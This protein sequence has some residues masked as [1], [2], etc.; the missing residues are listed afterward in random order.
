MRPHNSVS[1]NTWPSLRLS[2]VES[3]SMWPLGSEQ[4]RSLNQRLGFPGLPTLAQGGLQYRVPCAWPVCPSPIRRPP[5][6]LPVQT[7]LK[8]KV[9]LGCGSA[10]SL[11]EAEAVLPMLL[12][13]RMNLQEKKKKKKLSLL[14]EGS[15]RHFVLMTHFLKISFFIS[16]QVKSSLLFNDL[17]TSKLQQK[18]ASPQEAVCGLTQGPADSSVSRHTSPVLTPQDQ[19]RQR[20]RDRNLPTGRACPLAE[21]TSPRKHLGLAE[22]FLQMELY[23]TSFGHFFWRA[24][25]RL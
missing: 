13:C 1:I 6:Y 2:L 23:L 3:P 10:F 12:A 7:L 19:E 20:L 18:D 25:T 11:K 16:S 8:G 4:I 24:V 21:L 9:V 22:A 5:V 14:P 15:A 17:M